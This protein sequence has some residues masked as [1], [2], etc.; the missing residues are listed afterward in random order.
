VDFPAVCDRLTKHATDSG[1]ALRNPITDTAF[2]HPIPTSSRCVRLYY[3]GETEP[4]AIANADLQ[5]DI[6]AEVVTIVGFWAISSNG[7]L[8]TASVEEEMREWKH[9]F[10]TR[11]DGDHDLNGELGH[12]NLDNATTGF[13]TINGTIYRWTEIVARCEWEEYLVA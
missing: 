4:E 2:A 7:V 13:T 3:D 10:R 12:V 11:V 6:I 8:S 1:R 5:G 9:Q